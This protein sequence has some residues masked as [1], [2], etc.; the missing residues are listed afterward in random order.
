MPLSNLLPPIQCD[1]NNP[2]SETQG[3]VLVLG[4]FDGMHRGHQALVQR[5]LSIANGRD[6]YLLT[7]SPHPRVYFGDSTPFQ[8][9]NNQQKV[10]VVSELGMAGVVELPFA[11][12]VNLTPTQFMEDILV[13]LL[14][15]SHVVVGYD[16]KFA[17]NRVGG[18][19]DLSR[20]SSFETSVVEEITLY[21]KCSST[22]IRNAISDG[23][24]KSTCDML[25]RSY[26]IMGMVEHGK[27]LGRDIGFPTMNV[28]LGDYQRP[29]Y[30]VYAVRICVRDIWYDGVANIGVRPTVDG[31]SEKLEIYA[32]DFDAD[33]YDEM[34]LVDFIGY[35]RGEM[36]F[37]SVSQLQSQ[38]AQDVLD[39][40]KQ[41]T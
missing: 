26:Q 6:V 31:T 39:A 38:I 9:Q 35:I 25:N 1:M 24:M 41:L 2:V 23:D 34:V 36:A 19:A 4:N 13:S 20:N 8:L 37:E 29:K 14:G 22:A 12:V 5:A 17:K 30:G 33:A 18:I 7:F 27:K 15:V 10:S 40:K 16:F 28:A 32:F 3:A 21:G 11:E